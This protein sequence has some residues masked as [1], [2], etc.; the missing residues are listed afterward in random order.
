MNVDLPD[1]DG[2]DEEH[3]LA[4]VDLHR[5]VAQADDVALIGLRHAV[6]QDHRLRG[7]PGGFGGRWVDGRAARARARFEGRGR[8]VRHGLMKSDFVRS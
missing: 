8:R 2:P 4:L 3:E 7:G 5:D 6:E 1:P